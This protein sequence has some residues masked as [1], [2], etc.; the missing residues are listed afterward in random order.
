MVKFLRFH[1]SAGAT[2]YGIQ[3]SHGTVTVATGCPFS[4]TLKSTGE[5]AHIKEYL[6]PVDPTMVIC[7][8][9]NY[10]GHADELGTSLK[11]KRSSL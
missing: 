3:D 7:I 8:G 11:C 4:G 6:S 2:Q 5:K 10:K 1:N 9:L